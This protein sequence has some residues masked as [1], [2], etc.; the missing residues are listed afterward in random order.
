MHLFKSLSCHAVESVRGL[1]AQTVLDQVLDLAR[2]RVLLYLKI[3]L[4][5]VEG[6]VDVKR[7]F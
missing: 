2:D 1:I 4:E 7:R 5:L 3:L 6:V